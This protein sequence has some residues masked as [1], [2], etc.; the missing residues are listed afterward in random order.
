MLY[1]PVILGSLRRGRQTPKVARFIAERM[2][3]TNQAEVE[4][5][6]LLAYHFPIMEERLRSR[7]E[8]NSSTSPTSSASC[9]VIARSLCPCCCCRSSVFGIE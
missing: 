4:I 8:G 7:A 5:L 3:R 2:A 9:A 6:D 1:I